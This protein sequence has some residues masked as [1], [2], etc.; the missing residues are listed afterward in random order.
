MA[1]SKK[2]YTRHKLNGHQLKRLAQLA[3]NNG[4]QHGTSMGALRARGLVEDGDEITEQYGCHGFT[5]TI[6]L[7]CCRLTD[8]G[9][10]ALE[11][12]RAAGW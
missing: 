4:H 9:R 1:T 2:R 11:E 8:A 3:A 6:H 5:R 7:P 12:A 10:E